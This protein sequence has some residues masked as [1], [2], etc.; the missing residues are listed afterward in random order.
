MALQLLEA[1]HT[2]DVEFLL[3]KTAMPKVNTVTGLGETK[4]IEHTQWVNNY[5]Y[6][7]CTNIIQSQVLLYFLP[8]LY[9]LHMIVISIP[10][11]K[12]ILFNFYCST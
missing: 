2:G 6:T 7:P 1:D 4:F 5:T 11:S 3:K 12:Q 8:K 10:R 9:K